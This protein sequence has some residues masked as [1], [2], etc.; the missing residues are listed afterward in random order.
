MKNVLLLFCLTAYVAAQAPKPQVFAP[1]VISTGDF[2]SHAE[3]TPDGNTVYFL[4]LTPDID[5]RYWTIYVS[6]RVN[7]TWSKPQIA[8]FSGQYGDADPY[9]TPDGKKFFFISNRPLDPKETKARGDFDIWIM[10]RTSQGGWSEPK[11]LEGPVN[12]PATEYYPRTA[13]DGTLYFGSRREGGLG[14]SDIWRARLGADGTYQAPENL[15]PA[16]NVPGEDFEPYIAPDQSYL[17]FMSVRRGGLGQGDL[18]IS[19]NRNGQWT[20]AE[21][22]GEPFSSAGYEFAP[23]ISPDGKYFFFSSTRNTMPDPTTKLSTEAYEKLLHGPGNGLGDVY[24]IDV[25]ALP[26]K[27]AEPK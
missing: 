22:L 9:I 17:I 4:R 5:A 8:P 15:G 25:S 2:D 11:H 26:L 20:K 23:K 21:N 6:H 16:I 18:Y 14:A 1:G 27:P 3:F 12:S 7:G 13:A 19:Y 10:D 24:F